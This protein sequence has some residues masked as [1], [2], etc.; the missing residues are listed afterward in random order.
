[1]NTL[2]IFAAKDLIFLIVLAGIVIFLMAKTGAKK[3]LLKVGIIAAP[4]AYLIAKV[5]GHFYNNPRP[6]ISEHVIPLISH[7]NSNGFP[8]DHTLLG[9]TV[10]AVIFTYNK[11]WGII[12][13]VLALIV[14]YARVLAGVHHA[15]D[16]IGATVF[17]ILA[18]Y[19]AVWISKKFLKN[20]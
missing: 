17:A 8:S 16:I 7:D 6:F 13:G 1:M 5:A 2:I 20:I 3:E 15:V 18:T 19:I 10:A 12:L 9:V 11:K 4:L 14:G